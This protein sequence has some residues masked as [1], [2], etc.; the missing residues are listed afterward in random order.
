[1]RLH[2]VLGDSEAET[3]AA[4]LA[5][6]G[7]VDP[8]ETLEDAVEVLG[9]DSRPEVPHGELD[10]NRRARARRRRTRLPCFAILHGVFDEVAEDLDD[11]VGV[12]EDPCVGCAS[13]TRG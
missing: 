3:G 6:A 9:G 10:A 8:V 13:R 11:G 12:G 1:M 2:D 4:R 7:F 5:G